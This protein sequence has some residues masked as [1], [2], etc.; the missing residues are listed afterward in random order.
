M[1]AMIFGMT[2]SPVTV[3]V[4][5]HTKVTAKIAP[6]KTEPMTTARKI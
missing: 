3:S 2:I 6:T 4:I 1:R 5:S